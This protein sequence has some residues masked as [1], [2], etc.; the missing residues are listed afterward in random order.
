METGTDGFDEAVACDLEADHDF[1]IPQ[2]PEIPTPTIDL[3][4]GLLAGF[5]LAGQPR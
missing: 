2:P 4:G 5:R 3:I 1:E